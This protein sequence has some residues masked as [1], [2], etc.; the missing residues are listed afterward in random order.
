MRF[1]PPARQEGLGADA[2]RPPPQCAAVAILLGIGLLGLTLGTVPAAVGV[3][4]LAASSLGMARLA[5]KH[6]GGHTGDVLGALEQVGEAIILLTA[7]AFTR[8]G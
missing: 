6:I 7:A 2:G 5:L 1:V 3:M 4:L 8:A